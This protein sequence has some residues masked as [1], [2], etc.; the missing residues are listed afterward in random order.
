MARACGVLVVEDDAAIG[1]LVCDLLAGDT[2]GGLT[3]HHASLIGDHTARGFAAVVY[4]PF[5]PIDLCRP[6]TL[7][8]LC[9]LMRR[10]RPR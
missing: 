1:G 2:P 7:S 8:A 3:A 9:P 10:G 4:K 6:R 5:D